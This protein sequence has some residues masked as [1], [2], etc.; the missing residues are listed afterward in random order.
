MGR[1]DFLAHMAHFRRKI[2]WR[3]EIRARGRMFWWCH[4]CHN[5]GAVLLDSEYVRGA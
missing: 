3:K 2:M 1:E 4:H 5:G